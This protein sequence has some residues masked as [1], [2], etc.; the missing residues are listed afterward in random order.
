MRA[1][2]GH[3]QQFRLRTGTFRLL[4]T[5][6]NRGHDQNQNREQTR[7]TNHSFSELAV[8]QKGFPGG[9]SV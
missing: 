7:G 5:I 2:I 8:N 6:Q 9:L 4:I 3:F 1:L